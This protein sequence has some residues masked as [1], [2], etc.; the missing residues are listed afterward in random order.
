MEVVRAGGTAWL[1]YENGRGILVDAGKRHEGG[2]ILR[3]IRKLGVTV[4]LIFLTH[5]HYDHAG[6]AETLRVATGAKVMAGE[7][8]ARCIRE[9][10][11]PVPEGTRP[12]TRFLSR[13]AHRLQPNYREHYAPV[14]RDIV[15]A[16]ETGRLDEYGFDASYVYLGA[17]SP[18]STGLIIGEYYFIGDTVYGVG[19]KSLFPV[20]ADVPDDIP[21]AWLSIISSS[22]KKLCP[23]HG[24]MIAIER[25]KTEFAREFGDMTDA[26]QRK[27]RDSQ[28]T[29]A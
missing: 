17:H 11:S 20:F 1:V 18:G 7:R 25:L 19:K 9:G 13:A 5:T 24:R 16:G 4:P 29:R 12:L 8:E 15:E 23:G 10:C 3:R 14:T 22:A 28:G 6:S 27:G 21:A 26:I 2:G